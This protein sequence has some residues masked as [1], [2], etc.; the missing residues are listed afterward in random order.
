MIEKK[1]R[2]AAV[3]AAAPPSD[4]VASAKNGNTNVWAMTALTVFSHRDY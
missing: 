4:G 1:R 3:V 2:I